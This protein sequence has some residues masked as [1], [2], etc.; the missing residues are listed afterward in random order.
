MELRE[1]INQAI[2]DIVLA[3][4]SS[5]E[6]ASREICLD[7]QKNDRSIEFDIAVTV[8]NNLG[9]GHIKVLSF[10]EVGAESG[11]KNTTVTRIKFGVNVSKRT[12]EE[13]RVGVQKR[14][15][16]LRKIFIEDNR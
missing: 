6:A 12:K 14:F 4:D 13:Q 3:V 5:S 15:Q 7:D 16:N 1:F 10:L 9:G 11:S 8:E 2:N